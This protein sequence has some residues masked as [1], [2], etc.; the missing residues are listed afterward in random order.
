M[1]TVPERLRSHLLPVFLSPGKDTFS[2]VAAHQ[3]IDFFAIET[4]RLIT[5]LKVRSVVEIDSILVQKIAPLLLIILMRKKSKFLGKRDVANR[6][7]T[8]RMYRALTQEQVNSGQGT[9]G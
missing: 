4:F 6:V 8:H 5:V 7:V 1:N 9:N 2:V 3:P